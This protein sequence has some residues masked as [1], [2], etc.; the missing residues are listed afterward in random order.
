[1]PSRG[2]KRKHHIPKAFTYDEVRQL[3]QLRADGMR[4][5]DLM[6]LTGRCRDVIDKAIHGRGC[7]EGVI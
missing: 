7:Y 1:M 6:R 2:G 3:R 4:I 5:K